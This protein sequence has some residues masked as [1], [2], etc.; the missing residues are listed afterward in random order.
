MAATGAS[1]SATGAVSRTTCNLHVAAFSAT[2]YP[3]GWMARSSCDP[4][5]CP[6]GSPGERIQGLPGCSDTA[7]SC[8]TVIM[9][10][11]S[12][13]I[14]V[15]DGPGSSRKPSASGLAIVADGKARQGLSL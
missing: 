1:A 11:V 4:V 2:A 10:L 12:G 13:P 14:T 9:V 5:N 3:A 7:R 6:N 8:I 15:A